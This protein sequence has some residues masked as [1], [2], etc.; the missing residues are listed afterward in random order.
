M[1]KAIAARR[2]PRYDHLVKDHLDLQGA[3]GA[4]YRFRRVP[5]LADLPATSGN[6]VYVRWRGETAQVACC[7]AL[8]S[9]TSADRFWDAAVRDHAAEAVYVRLNV[10]RAVR[11]VEHAD[12]AGGLRPPMAPFLEA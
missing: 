10:A 6:F 5:D 1:S 7:G 2:E 3:S 9:L 11:D 12:L 8:N 4:T